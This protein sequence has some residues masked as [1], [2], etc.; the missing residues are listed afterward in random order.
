MVDQQIAFSWGSLVMFCILCT[1]LKYR[2]ADSSVPV[3]FYKRNHRRSPRWFRKR[4]KSVDDIYFK[5]RVQVTAS[6]PAPMWQDTLKDS[7]SI[8]ANA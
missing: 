6:A 4:F 5:I 8:S 3:F 2:H 7:G 1:R